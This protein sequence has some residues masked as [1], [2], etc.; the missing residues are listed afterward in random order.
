MPTIVVHPWDIKTD[1]DMG[2]H[3][4]APGIVTGL[5]DHRSNT[6]AGDLLGKG[7]GKHF[8]GMGRR[9]G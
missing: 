8:G 1:D 7:V 3:Y 5:I 2:P 6:D 4:V 9:V